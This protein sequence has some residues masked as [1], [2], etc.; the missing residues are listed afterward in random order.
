MAVAL[1]SGFELGLVHLK[2][3]RLT[4]DRLARRRHL[5]FHEPEGPPGFLLGGADAQQQLI[6]LGQALAH[7][8][9]FAQQASQSLAPHGVLFG[10]P[11]TA[12]GQHI[13]FAFVLIQL[14]LHR[15]A[16]LLPR[17]IQP[18]L[19]MLVD[20]AFGVPTK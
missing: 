17:Q 13:E 7:H 2:R 9:Q 14:H 1:L 15:V 11:P 12:L 3:E 6:A 10:L 8:P 19:F 16:N 5:N 18:L 20:F 4:G